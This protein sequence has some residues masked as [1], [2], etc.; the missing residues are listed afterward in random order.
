[1]KKTFASLI[2]LS[3]LTQGAI[4]QTAKSS[5]RPTALGVSFILT[6]FTTAQRIRNGSLSKLI[7]NHSWA[8][9]REMGP[10]LALTYFKGLR[11]HIDFAGSLGASFVTYPI[12]NKTFSS[13]NLLLEADASAN[14]KMFTEDYWFTPYFSLG[15]GASKYLGYYG[16][17][18]PVGAGVKLNLF[19]EA[20]LF[21]ASQYRI[22]VTSET[23]NYHFTYSIGVSGIIGK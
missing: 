17:F 9:L 8:K 13:D 21:I 22:P 5:I 19:N 20:S 16:A 14:F 18:L 6:D 10:G 3:F 1:M 12:P 11:P 15:V 23:T 2:I 7:S 4:A